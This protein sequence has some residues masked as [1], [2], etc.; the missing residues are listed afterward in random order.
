MLLGNYMLFKFLCELVS[1]NYFVPDSLKLSQRQQG[2]PNAKSRPLHLEQT[3][4]IDDHTL[5]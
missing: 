5:L 4:F 2:V 1:P 3:F